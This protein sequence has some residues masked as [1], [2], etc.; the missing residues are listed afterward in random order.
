MYKV[1]VVDDE[2][3]ML[4]GWKTM[5]DWESCGYELCGTATDGEEALASIRAYDP[6][7]VITDIRMPVLDGLG[8]IQAM[9]DRGT[10]PKPSS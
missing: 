6:E 5:V 9:K 2:P 8:L 4:E 3:L 10:A 1:L 7:L